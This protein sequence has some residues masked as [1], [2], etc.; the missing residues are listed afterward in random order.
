[1]INE[2]AIELV[3][4]DPADINNHYVKACQD[5]ILELMYEPYAT[6]KRKKKRKKQD[7]EDA[8]WNQYGDEVYSDVLG[9]KNVP[10]DVYMNTLFYLVGRKKDGQWAYD[11]VKASF[12]TAFKKTLYYRLKDYYESKSCE[13]T[14]LSLDQDLDSEDQ[15]GQT[16]HDITADKNSENKYNAALSKIMGL[17]YI[18]DTYNDRI[19][20]KTDKEKNYYKGFFTFDTTKAVKSDKELGKVACEYSDALFPYMVVALLKHLMTGNFGRIHDVVA[21]SLRDGVDL[22]K[23]GEL[24][25]NYFGVSHPTLSKYSQLYDGLRRT[26]LGSRIA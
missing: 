21:N 4:Y 17:G 5:T 11:P 1:M 19:A 9:Y 14:P 23:R 24:M 16:L 10:H 6:N 22:N 20:A 25:E 2:K 13:N 12:I 7:G 3:A 26:V 15:G 8:F 18:M